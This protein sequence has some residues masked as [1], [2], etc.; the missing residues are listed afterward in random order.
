[1]IEVQE[2]LAVNLEKKLEILLLSL[3][4]CSKKDY[5]NEKIAQE[6]DFKF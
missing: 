5:F 6:E 4:V 1:M 3:N 2:T